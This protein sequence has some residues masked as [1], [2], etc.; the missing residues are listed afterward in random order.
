MAINYIIPIL[1]KK[2]KDIENE[3]YLKCYIEIQN[4]NLEKAV[5]IYSA[6]INYPY[7]LTYSVIEP[8]S[9]SNEAIELLDKKVKEMVFK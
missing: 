5:K 8:K 4:N 7:N 9:L 6:F 3:N 2:A 1:E